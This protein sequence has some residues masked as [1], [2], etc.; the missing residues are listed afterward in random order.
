M[1]PKNA[2]I[3]RNFGRNF[4]FFDQRVNIFIPQGKRKNSTWKKRKKFSWRKIMINCQY[5]CNSWI[6]FLFLMNFFPIFP[7]NC[8]FQLFVHNF[9]QNSEKF[10]ALR[11]ICSSFRAILC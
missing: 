7:F 10:L 5:S 11:A 6:F 8:L 2:D 3:I 9:R 4:F 1:L